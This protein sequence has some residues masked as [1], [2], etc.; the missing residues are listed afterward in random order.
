VWGD[1]LR[2]LLGV[3]AAGS[4][5]TEAPVVPRQ[6]P[7]ARRLAKHFRGVDERRARSEP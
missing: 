3:A 1:A 6:V 2:R 5:K 7:R 4:N